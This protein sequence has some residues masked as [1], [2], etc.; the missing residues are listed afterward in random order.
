MMDN[1]T[2]RIGRHGGT[3][4]MPSVLLF[5]GLVVAPLS[6][7]VVHLLREPALGSVKS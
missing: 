6:G 1:G 4:N 5:C 7:L 3:L 2:V